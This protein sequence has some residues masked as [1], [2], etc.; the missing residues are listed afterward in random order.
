MSVALIVSHLSAL[1]NIA[2]MNVAALV[3]EAVTFMRKF[4]EVSLPDKKVM[5]IQA[6]ERIAAGADGVAGTKDDLI[7]SETVAKIKLLLDNQLLDGFVEILADGTAQKVAAS[8]FG[9]FSKK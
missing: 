8:C 3:S 4:P 9:C 2:G 7:P 6:F 5:L 1:P